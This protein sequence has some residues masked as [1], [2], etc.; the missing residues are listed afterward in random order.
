IERRMGLRHIDDFGAY[1]SCL[2]DHPNEVAALVKDLLI[3][4][5]S[6]F[7]DPEA[8]EALAHDVL[9]PLIKD[10]EPDGPLRIWVPGCATG[11]EPYSI[12]ILL[13]E[14]LAAAQKAWGVQIFATD[15]N[16][17]ALAAARLGIYPASIVEDVAPDRLRRFFSQIDEHTYQIAKVI[18]ESVA[19]AIQD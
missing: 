9:K 17:D 8:W 18:R 10:C 5:T 11:E 7:R 3:G 16:E 13:H 14:E 2:R 15:I 1:L 6:F 19:F 12:A 4:V